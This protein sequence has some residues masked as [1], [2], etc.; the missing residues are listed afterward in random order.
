MV[1]PAFCGTQE[2][3]ACKLRS[4]IRAGLLSAWPAARRLLAVGGKLFVGPTL[5]RP[6]LLWSATEGL[7]RTTISTEDAGTSVSVESGPMAQ[8]GLPTRNSPRRPATAKLVWM[9]S[10]TVPLC[11]LHYTVMEGFL[12][13]LGYEFA[14][15]V[16]RCRH[17]WCRRCYNEELGYLTPVNREPAQD[18]SARPRCRLHDSCMFVSG[19]DRQRDTVRYVCPETACPSLVTKV[20]T[21]S[22]GKTI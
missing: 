9:R 1:T 18:V 12:A 14:I 15:E 11:D 6:S 7:E 16:W 22:L 8:R 4:W 19:V 2:G 20:Q 21:S 13:P 10:D 5:S 3:W 17:D